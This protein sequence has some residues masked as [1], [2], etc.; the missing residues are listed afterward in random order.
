MVLRP[1]SVITPSKLYRNCFQTLQNNASE[2]NLGTLSSGHRH[3]F[4]N[5]IQETR[6]Y[7]YL[8]TETST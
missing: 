7:F 6:T 5:E 3:I 4:K 2:F 8:R 1:S